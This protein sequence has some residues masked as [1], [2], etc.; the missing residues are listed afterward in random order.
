MARDVLANYKVQQRVV[1]CTEYISQ[2]LSYTQ[3]TFKRS[4]S[5]TDVLPFFNNCFSP[6]FSYGATDLALASQRAQYPLFFRTVPTEIV[7]NEPRLR[8]IQHFGWKDEIGLIYD[9]SPYYSQVGFPTFS[10]QF[11]YR[12]R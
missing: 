7:F 2:L 1:E 11:L 8:F 10:F 3:R 6:Q 12:H 9:A 4:V 5:K